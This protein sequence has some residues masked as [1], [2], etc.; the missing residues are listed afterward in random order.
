MILT[1]AATTAASAEAIAATAV[2]VGQ[3]GGFGAD[4]VMGVV[5]GVSVVDYLSIGVVAGVV[6]EISLLSV[7]MMMLSPLGFKRL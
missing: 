7:T 6:G 5:V 2:D 3:R 1:S 4:A